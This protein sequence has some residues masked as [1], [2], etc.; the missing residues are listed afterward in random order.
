MKTILFATVLAAALLGAPAA[1]RAAPPV[2]SPE[3][4]EPAAAE[5]AATYLSRLAAGQYEEALALNDLRGMRQYLLDRRLSE[6]KAKNPELTQKDLDEM[7]AQLQ[8][9][10]LNPARLREI[11]LGVMREAA[12]QGMTWKILAFAPAPEQAGS[13]L[14]RIDTR[15]AAGKE[16][17][18]LLGI[19]KLGEQWFVAPEVVEELMARKPV[20]QVVPNV[21]P[22]PEVAAQVEQFWKQWQ[23]GELDSAYPLLSPEYRNRVPLLT[24]LQQA[25]DLIA[26]AGVPAAWSIVQCRELAPDILGLGVNV[27]GSTTGIQSLMIFKKTGETWILDDVQYRPAGSQPGAEPTGPAAAPFRMNLRPDFKPVFA[28]DAAAPAAGKPATGAP[29]APA[30]GQPAAPAIPAAP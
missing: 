12:Y 21:P 13:H 11:L 16:K 5:L 9:N 8:V 2:F 6:L 14:V 17:P 15:T 30:P 4:P 19:K 1:L 25:Q 29:P 3:P 23:S 28:P 10:E 22:P 26:K 18:I 24:F 7:S 27:N 20:I